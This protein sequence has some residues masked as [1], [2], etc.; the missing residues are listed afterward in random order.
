[1]S[2]VYGS[3]FNNGQS[4]LQG[5]QNRIGEH[6]KEMQRLNLQHEQRVREIGISH[7]NSL[8]RFHEEHQATSAFQERLQNDRFGHERGMQSAS[9]A[10]DA[11]MFERKSAWDSSESAATRE[12]EAKQASLGR[13]A[14]TRMENLKH[15]NAFGNRP[16]AFDA[17]TEASGN[18]NISSINVGG[19]SLS[20]RA[21]QAPAAAAK[22][23]RAPRP[24]KP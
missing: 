23:P 1:M 20:T 5:L 22:T 14:A 19:A 9:Q 10:H 13:S 16:S 21:P 7:Q 8:A 12:H 11:E 6:R 17:M 3:G 15:K 2:E 18:P 24:K 4:P